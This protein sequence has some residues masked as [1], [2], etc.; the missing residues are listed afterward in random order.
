MPAARAQLEAVPE[1]MSGGEHREKKLRQF[2]RGLGTEC[3]R[4]PT[5]LP[6]GSQTNLRADTEARKIICPAPNAAR[7]VLSPPPPRTCGR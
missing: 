1:N 3:R 7:G 5:N 2:V 4:K 6:E